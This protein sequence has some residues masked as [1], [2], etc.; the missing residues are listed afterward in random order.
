MYLVNGI[1][2]SAE[3][4]EVSPRTARFYNL[5]AFME[6]FFDTLDYRAD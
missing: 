1:R 4:G 3:R 6:R 2:D 5:L